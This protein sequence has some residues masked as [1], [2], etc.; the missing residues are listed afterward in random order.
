[1]SILNSISRLSEYFRRH[2]FAATLRRAR[3]AGKR[4]IFARRMVVFC[5]DLNERELVRVNAP[6]S[7]RVERLSVLSELSAE[8]LREMS[9]FWNTRLV[10]QNI[11]ER[12]EKGALLW[13]VECEGRLA[14]YGW[15]L[16]GGAI[17][18]YYF[19][20]TKNDVHLFDF[21]VFPPY[22]GRGINP[23]LI[24]QILDGLAT[25]WAA[26]A[27]IEA[28]E[29]NDAQLSSLRK[30]RFSCLG[31]AR[32]FTI[33]GHTFVSWMR[34]DDVMQMHKVAKPT[35]EILRTPSSNEQ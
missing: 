29:W 23:Y 19:P 8:H 11:R 14:G 24:G 7:L 2:G 12:F 32:S 25:N 27:F 21:H 10:N 26:R 5:C 1:M 31:L 22:R 16:Q 4:A 17:E 13:L 20:L 34:N 30:T 33:F 28:A 35:D 9:S 15:T 18:P 6:K 3:L